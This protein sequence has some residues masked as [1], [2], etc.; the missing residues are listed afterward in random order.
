MSGKL[1]GWKQCLLICLI[2]FSGVSHA[3]EVE[4]EVSLPWQEQEIAFPAAPLAENWLPFYVSAATDN[5]FFVDSASLGVGSDGVVRYV[6]L[7]QTPG[8][9]RNV[10][11][12]GMRC[13]T[14]ERRI[15]ALGRSDGA[16]VKARSSDWVRIRAVGSNRYHAALFSDFLCPDG[17]VARDAET[18]REAFRRAARLGAWVR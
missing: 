8:G 4:E 13:E 5:R 18:I 14:S 9:V 2:G 12:E 16:W 7:I 6:L 10:S 17:V 11:Y 1:P 3:L 15:Y